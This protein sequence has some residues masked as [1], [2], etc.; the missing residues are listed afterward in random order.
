MTLVLQVQSF[1]VLCRFFSGVTGSNNLPDYLYF[2][3]TGFVADG[4]VTTQAVV[5]STLD[6]LLTSVPDVGI[7]VPAVS[8]YT[9][10]TTVVPTTPNAIFIAIA[11]YIGTKIQIILRLSYMLHSYG[12]FYLP[13]LR[14][15]Q[16]EH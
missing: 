2:G 11:T 7:I 16:Q 8:Y 3:Y 4:T 5:N 9:A 6:A 12:T 15:L 1:I 10:A 14:L 13:M